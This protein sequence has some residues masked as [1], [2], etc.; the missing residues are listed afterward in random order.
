MKIQPIAVILLRSA[1]LLILS[2]CLFADDLTWGGTWTGV[3]SGFGTSPYTAIDTSLSKNPTIFCL[4]FND[5]IGPPYAWQANIYS[6]SQA[7]VTQNAQFGGNYGQGVPGFNF[8]I[9]AAP[10]AFQGRHRSR[11][12]SFCKFG[13][14]PDRVHSISRSGLALHQHPPGADR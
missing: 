9:S 4:D 12:V 14:Q 10:F 6:L 7:N 13:R 1:A 8:N 3:W 2:G 11:S 5:E